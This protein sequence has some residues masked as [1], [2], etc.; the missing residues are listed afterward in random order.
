MKRRN[1]LLSGAAA[2]VTI[3]SVQSATAQ[4]CAA[5]GTQ[6]N[7]QIGLILYT[8]RDAMKTPED[9]I[10]ALE[11]VSQI[12]YRNIELAGLGPLSVDDWA[13][14]TKDN[15]LNVV[16]AHANFGAMLNEP[17]KE[18]DTYKKLGCSHLVCSWMPNEYPRTE[19]GFKK[20]AEDCNT[21]GANMQTEGVLYGYH[22]HDFEFH[23]YNGICGEEILRRNTDPKLVKFEVDTY[24]VQAGGASP[25]SWVRAMFGR[26]YCIHYK[27]MM[28]HE[29]KQ[30]FAEVGEGNL[31][32]QDINKA[33]QEIGARYCIVEQ[34]SSLRDPMESIEISYK[35]MRAMGLI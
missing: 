28:M 10:K 15:G 4:C 1:F 32:W 30:R 29:G 5:M 20:F 22:N 13:K 33:A 9:T 18:A 16:S 11:R 31:D 19:E 3:N 26:C 8:I 27:D 7:T 14:V 23:R 12:G 25:A 24:W 17:A 34:D 35:N 21:A 6:P 2:A